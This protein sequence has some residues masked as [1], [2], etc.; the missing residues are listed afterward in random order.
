MGTFDNIFVL[1]GLITHLII[2]GENF[3]VHLWTFEK[4]LTL[5]TGI[6]FGS[7]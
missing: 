7:N 3:I 2:R 1:H 5:L 4:H 6:Y